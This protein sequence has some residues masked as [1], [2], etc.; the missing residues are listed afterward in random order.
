MA[1]TIL[2]DSA[3]FLRLKYRFVFEDP[4]TL[5]LKGKG[6]VSVWRLLSRSPA[7]LATVDMDLTA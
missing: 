6:M 3:T 5:R 2:C 7:R 4:V 1:N